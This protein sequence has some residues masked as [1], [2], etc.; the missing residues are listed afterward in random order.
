[1]PPQ[2]GSPSKLFGES[3]KLKAGDAKYYSLWRGRDGLLTIWGKE[4]CSHWLAAADCWRSYAY[5]MGIDGSPL[6]PVFLLSHWAFAKPPWYG[7]NSNL[8]G[9]SLQS[10]WL[11]ILSVFWYRLGCDVEMVAMAYSELFLAQQVRAFLATELSPH[12]FGRGR[13]G[14]KMF[15]G[16]LGLYPGGRWLLQWVLERGQEDWYLMAFL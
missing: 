13:S 9:T 15:G 8:R 6:I 4:I 11:L 3:A 7:Q 10:L 12:V 14:K 5:E 16:Y 1:M 2:Y